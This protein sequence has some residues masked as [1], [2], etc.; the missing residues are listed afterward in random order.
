MVDIFWFHDAKMS[1]VSKQTWI[2]WVIKY[3]FEKSLKKAY[4]IRDTFLK[5]K[6]EAALSS[7]ADSFH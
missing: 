5:D 1:D 4:T 3:Y 6:L 7:S 2:T